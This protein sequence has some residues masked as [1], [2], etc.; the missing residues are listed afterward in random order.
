[1]QYMQDEHNLGN[2]LLGAKL[3]KRHKLYGYD[4]HTRHQFVK[5]IFQMQYSFHRAKR[6]WYDEKTNALKANGLKYN[7]AYLELYEAHVPP[8]RRFYHILHVQPS[9]WI[10]VYPER[11]TKRRPNNRTS[12]DYEGVL[13]CEEINPMNEKEAAVPYK[14][15]SFDI[16]ADSSHGDFP[17]PV[18]TFR[19]LAIEIVNHF[20]LEKVAFTPE[21]FISSVLHALYEKA[22]CTYTSEGRPISFNHISHVYM[23]SPIFPEEEPRETDAE[24][25]RRTISHADAYLRVEQLLL[26][27]VQSKVVD[28]L[29]AVV[30]HEDSRQR[31]ITEYFCALHKSRAR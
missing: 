1:M 19:K 21:Y 8:L 4:G 2:N 17:V 7:N 25:G 3:L 12:C 10:R 27:S 11:L 18:K 30:N 28:I 29:K 26:P 5:L 15:C 31:Q 20:V 22:N 24:K 14:V 23:K 9:G 13:M 16:E 6:V